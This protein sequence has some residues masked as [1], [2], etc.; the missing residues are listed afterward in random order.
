MERY[1]WFGSRPTD[2]YS[3]QNQ[4]I[5]LDGL[6]SLVCKHLTRNLSISATDCSDQLQDQHCLLLPGCKGGGR[7]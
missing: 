4:R 2:V 5:L 1:L 7:V 3:L 6:S